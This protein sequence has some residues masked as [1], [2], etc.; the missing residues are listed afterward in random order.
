MNDRGRPRRYSFV[1]IGFEADAGLLQLQARSMRLYCPPELIEEIIVVDNSWPGSRD[2]RQELLLHYGDLAESVRI[3]PA[4]EIAE[5]PAGFHGWFTQQ[6]LKIKVA[7]IVRSD[8][9]VILDAKNHLIATLD[10]EFLETFAGQ[11]R[12]NG[13]SYAGHPMREYLE[14]SLKYLGVDPRGYIDWFI[15]ITTPFTMVT[16]E[17][18]ELIRHVE[19]KEG[20]PFA[21]VFLHRKL[22]EFFLYSG[23]LASKGSLRQIYDVTQPYQPQLWPEDFNHQVCAEAIG[24]ANHANCYFMTIHR[25][26]LAKMDARTKVLVAEFWHD[27]GLFASVEDAGRFLG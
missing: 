13:Y 10:R 4:A 24:E 8:R 9:F 2:W 14:R 23:F 16:C 20:K 5:M 21:S 12:T 3:V 11:P 7:S 25:L 26:A 1:T 19:Q 15:R 22:S 18:C 6:V 27:R 17:A